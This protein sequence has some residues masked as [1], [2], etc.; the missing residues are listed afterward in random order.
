MKFCPSCTHNQKP[1]IIR[2]KYNHFKQSTVPTCM[3][4]TSIPLTWPEQGV[5]ISSMPPFQQSHSASGMIFDQVSGNKRFLTAYESI[6]SENKNLC[7]LSGSTAPWS[8]NYEPMLGLYQYWTL[9]CRL[10]PVLVSKNRPDPWSEAIPASYQYLAQR[11]W[12]HTSFIQGPYQSPYHVYTIYLPH[13]S[14]K[15]PL[16]PIPGPGWYESLKKDQIQYPA[17][18]KFL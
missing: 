11:H 12:G 17:G 8:M 13:T 14:Q 3:Q 6:T 16:D 5:C 1:I 2:E 9:V 4:P 18:K 10:V 7:I 15:S